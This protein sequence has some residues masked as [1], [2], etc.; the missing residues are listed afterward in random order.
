MLKRIAVE[1]N[2]TAKY[3]ALIIILNCYEYY[4]ILNKCRKDPT[5]AKTAHNLLTT[6]SLKAQTYFF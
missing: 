6:C 3:S 4:S 2:N 1:T 5:D